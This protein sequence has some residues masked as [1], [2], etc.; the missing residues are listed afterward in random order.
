[1]QN[2]SGREV[3]I[4]YFSESMWEWELSYDYLPDAGIPDAGTFD[5]DVHA[6]MGF[7][8]STYGGQYPFLYRDPDNCQ[9]TGSYIGTTDGRR[10]NYQI[11]Y[12]VIPSAGPT[13]TAA[14]GYVDTSQLFKVYLDNVLQSASSYE[15][16]T[17]V[18]GNQQI[19]FNGTPPAG[20]SITVDMSFLFFARFIDPVY[21]FE[22][23]LSKIWL[24]K[25]ITLA[26]RR[27]YQ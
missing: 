20:K 15:V 11:F 17:H 8:Q 27:S 18:W 13:M 26:S 5:S 1:M 24:A 7:F 21:S 6:L 4:P 19:N 23:F 3:R 9:T 25:K 10:G 22:E 16:L 14:V 2:Q 12:S